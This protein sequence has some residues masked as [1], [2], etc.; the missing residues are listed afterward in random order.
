MK[1]S[2]IN[3]IV[4]SQLFGDKIE[5]IIN[6]V[7]A[8]VTNANNEVLCETIIKYAKDNGVTELNIIDKETLNQ[9]FE[10]AI[11]Y[12]KM[13]SIEEKLGLTFEEIALICNVSLHFNRISLKLN[14]IFRDALIFKRNLQNKT[15]ACEYSPVND[16]D[17]TIRK[18]TTINFKDFGKTWKF[19]ESNKEE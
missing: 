17:N 4:I 9:V 5:N 2:L 18:A 10:D 11:K 8:V 3:T 16:N 7:G 13:K 12:R 15:F 1:P 19:R 14:G 6:K